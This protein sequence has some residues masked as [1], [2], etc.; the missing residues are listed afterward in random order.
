MRRKL[1]TLAAGVSAVLCV[2]VCVLWVRSYWVGESLSGE[3]WERAFRIYSTRG[4]FGVN[5]FWL[6]NKW[7]EPLFRR[8]P[9]EYSRWPE[10]YPQR[11]AEDLGAARVVRLPGFT[12]Y[13]VEPGVGGGNIRLGEWTVGVAYVL[14]AALFVVLPALYVRRLLRA[15]HGAG[16][17]AAC[18][19]DLR[20][21]PGRCPECGAVPPVAP[22]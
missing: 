11:S 9:T 12:H 22:L 18:G 2:G 7:G 17:C 8:K 19:Y 6:Y 4:T 5:V 20:A 16:R 1:F 13:T 10:P 3:R 15:R 21:T 14:P